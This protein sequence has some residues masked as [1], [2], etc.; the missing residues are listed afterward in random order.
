MRKPGEHGFQLTFS[1]IRKMKASEAPRASVTSTGRTKS[2]TNTSVTDRTLYKASCPIMQKQ[3]N[4]QQK[5]KIR[6]K[7]IGKNTDHL[8]YKSCNSENIILN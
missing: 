1:L 7:R 6:N 4:Q 8:N 3:H 5:K 2:K